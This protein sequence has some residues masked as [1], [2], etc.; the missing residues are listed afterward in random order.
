MQDVRCRTQ[1]G[2]SLLLGFQH[3]LRQLDYV[4]LSC[5]T[6]RAWLIFP[7]RRQASLFFARI[8]DTIEWEG[9]GGE[10]DFR[11]QDR[12][13]EAQVHDLTPLI[14]RRFPAG[15]VVQKATL[16]PFSIITASMLLLLHVT[17]RSHCPSKWTEISVIL[18]SKEVAMGWCNSETTP[19][20]LVGFLAYFLARWIDMPGM[21]PRTRRS[22]FIK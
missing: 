5:Y 16:S 8:K 17:S 4:C 11:H 7:S 22:L 2:F 18:L 12:S 19:R 9:E 3:T 10:D 15:G 20:S 14:E 21:L 6:T 1:C 13:L